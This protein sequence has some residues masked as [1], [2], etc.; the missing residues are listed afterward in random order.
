MPILGGFIGGNESSDED[1]LIVESSGGINLEDDVT[2]AS[3]KPLWKRWLQSGMAV[4]LTVVA[5][6]I[7]I[8]L[9]IEYDVF[10]KIDDSLKIDEAWKPTVWGPKLAFWKEGA[11][12]AKPAVTA[13]GAVAGAVESNPTGA[14][15]EIGVK[16]SERETYSAVGKAKQM[17]KNVATAS[18][19][20]N[21]VGGVDMDQLLKY[22]L[23]TEDDRANHRRWA[24][25]ERPF[26][27]GAN[28]YIQIADERLPG[29]WVGFQRPRYTASTD[30]SPYSTTSQSTTRDHYNAT[31]YEDPLVF[32]TSSGIYD[33]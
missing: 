25:G 16:A 3:E 1:P 26:T 11:E 8:F 7:V 28:E 19:V 30:A 13:A 21:A 20:A 9:L 6:F 5:T 10:A 2:T 14:D 17:K 15:G 22:Q 12:D 32:G 23:T 18:S 24:A 29:S 31:R 27:G 33:Q 4:F